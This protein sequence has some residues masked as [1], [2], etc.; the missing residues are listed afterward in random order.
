MK[1]FIRMRVL[2]IVTLQEARWGF[3]KIEMRE[4]SRSRSSLCHSAYQSSLSL[5]A[6]FEPPQKAGC[7]SNMVMLLCSVVSHASL[8][9]ELARCDPE[10]TRQPVTI[11]LT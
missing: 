5:A 11:D 7:S 2:S 9:T 4:I 1:N 6:L 3:I 8:S 10:N